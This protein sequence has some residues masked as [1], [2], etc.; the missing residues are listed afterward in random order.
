[1]CVG[2]AP[3]GNQDSGEECDDGNDVAADGCTDRRFD[4]EITVIKV[5]NPADDTMFPFLRLTIPVL[6][7]I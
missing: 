7:S 6:R 2:G 1:L 4:C 3:D 5:A